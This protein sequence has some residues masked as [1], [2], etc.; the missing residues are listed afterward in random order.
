MSLW[1]IQVTLSDDRHAHDRLTA[2]LAGQR[3]WSQLV[4]PQDAKIIADVVVELSGADGL[5]TLL[6]ELHMISSQV[7]V[8]SAD[9]HRRPPRPPRRRAG[10]HRQP[11]LG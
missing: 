7:F 2:A 1:R 9:P 8:S 5:D 10:G 11:A 4:V 6:Y 3:V